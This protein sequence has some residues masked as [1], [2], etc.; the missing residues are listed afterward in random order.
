VLKGAPT[1]ARGEVPTAHARRTDELR[2]GSNRQAKQRR[3]AVR[4]EVHMRKLILVAVGLMPA[5]AACGTSVRTGAYSP[6][7]SGAVAG[8][9]FAWNEQRDRVS[10]DPRLENNQFFEDRLHEAIEWELGLRG[11]RHDEASPDLLVHH[12]LTLDNHELAQEVTN[13]GG[14]STTEVY[15]YEGGTIVV[16]IVDTRTNANLWLGWAE[17][18]V[19]PALVGPDAMR[20][21]V[22]DLVHTM[23]RRWPTPQRNDG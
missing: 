15:E 2:R 9:T 3:K 22:Y 18:A 6:P 8:A 5:L 14:Y 16:H 7:G 10:G 19:E 4:G 13:E 11:I 20:T 12:H 21:W 23:F 17:A 1:T